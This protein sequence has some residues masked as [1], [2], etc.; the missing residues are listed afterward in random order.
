MAYYTVENSHSFY[1]YINFGDVTN[2]MERSK[3]S[4]KPHTIKFISNSKAGKTG[5]DC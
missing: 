4:P 2:N 1:L 5:V 3:Q